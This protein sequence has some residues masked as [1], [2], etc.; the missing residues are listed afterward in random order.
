MWGWCQIPETQMP[1]QDSAEW[2]SFVSTRATAVSMC[3]D[4]D[5]TAVIVRMTVVQSIATV[6][7]SLLYIVPEMQSSLFEERVHREW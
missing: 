1:G 3:P 5:L 4:M 6:S 2:G 7:V